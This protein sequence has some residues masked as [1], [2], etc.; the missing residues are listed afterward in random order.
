MF[1]KKIMTLFMAVA[2]SVPCT[3]SSLADTASITMENCGA[4]LFEWRPVDCGDGQYFVILAGGNAIAESDVILNRGYD[5]A[6]T[7]ESMQYSRPW[8]VVPAL[9]NIDGVWGIPENWSSLPEGSQP[10]TQIV[11]K[12]NNKNLS[13]DKRIINVV[14]LPGGVSPAD[15]PASV[16]KYLINIDGSDAGAYVETDTNGWK[17]EEDG[18][19]RYKKPDGTYITGS[20]LNLDEKQYYLDEEGYMLTDTTTPDGVYVNAAGEATKYTPG[21]YQ[22]ERGWKY[23]LRNGYFAASTWVQDTD[24][25]YYYFDIGGYM[26]T[27]YDTPDGF[28]VGADGVWDGNASTATANGKNLGPGAQANSAAEETQAAEGEKNVTAEGTEESAENTE[29]QQESTASEEA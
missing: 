18:R 6:Y 3:F 27:D 23:V 1:K 20:W 12:T 13:T 19:W 24:G 4:Y 21:W 17:K 11:L 7:F 25:K 10:T 14:H 9:V 28:H 29:S 26:R 22:N 2:I 15:L 8:G 16:R 5:Y